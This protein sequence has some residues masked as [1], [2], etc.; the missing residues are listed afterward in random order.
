MTNWIV[1]EAGSRAGLSALTFFRQYRKEYGSNDSLCLIDDDETFRELYT[2]LYREGVSVLSK[3]E[4]DKMWHL[5][6]ALYDNV[7]FPADE[8]TRQSGCPQCPS[9]W[10]NMV[11]KCYYDKR[12]VTKM[13]ERAG[14][15]VPA[16]L[17]AENVIVKPNSMSAGSKGIHT[18]DDYCVQQR[19]NVKHEYVVDMFVDEKKNIVQLFPREVKLR[20]GY[21]KYI[22][23]LCLDHKVA[24]FAKSI[25]AA[26]SIGIFRGPCHVQIIEDAYGRLYFV[27]GSK[28]ISG[29]SIVNIL[30][31]YNPFALL[32]N[33]V[34]EYKEVDEEWHLF[35]DLLVKVM[36]VLK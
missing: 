18:F 31:G 25:V 9:Y 8:L 23:F 29:S 33:I 6:G 15:S 35:D 22:R 14:V 34:P 27:E 5:E 30:R 19:I 13:L 7:V 2:D 36:E 17:E 28:R 4:L 21:D 32:N 12:F 24:K 3:S 11:F 20:A 16:T 10:F 1:F 26:D